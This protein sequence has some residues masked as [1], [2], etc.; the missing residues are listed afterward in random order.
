MRGLNTFPFFRSKVE[1]L[2]KLIVHFRQ[3]TIREIF[4]DKMATIEV[5]PFE[6][7]A[8][9]ESETCVE[10]HLVNGMMLSKNVSSELREDVYGNS[11]KKE[12]I[13]RVVIG[14][15]GHWHKVVELTINNQIY[16]HDEST[17]FNCDFQ[18][19]RFKNDWNKN[20]GQE[21]PLEAISLKILVFAFF[22]WF[23]TW[24]FPSQIL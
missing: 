4:C 22:N 14:Q 18:L 8:K 12:E 19:L 15:K 24:L 21:F 1:I 16:S 20:F 23:L 5:P 2:V 11:Y 13:V 6:E 10:T 7:L 9:K 3:Y 17:S